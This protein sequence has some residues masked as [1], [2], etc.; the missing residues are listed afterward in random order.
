M[1]THYFYLSFLLVI[2][3]LNGTEIT[4]SST[5]SRDLTGQNKDHSSLWK[6]ELKSAVPIDAEKTMH[7]TTYQFE[8]DFV[9][10]LTNGGAKFG[11]NQFMIKNGD[12]FIME[13]RISYLIPMGSLKK[14][15]EKTLL[16]DFT[17]LSKKYQVYGI[18]NS[19]TKY[20]D[21]TISIV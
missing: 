2:L 16:L 18:Y 5:E 4:Y 10:R 19:K 17:Y 14:F 1:K 15:S 6:I 13:P 3:S 8:D 11:K 9:V 20:I 7:L 12:Y 21:V